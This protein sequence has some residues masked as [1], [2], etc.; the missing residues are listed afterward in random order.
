MRKFLRYVFIFLLIIFCF[1]GIIY[2][3]CINYT[4]INTRTTIVLSDIDL[5]NEVDNKIRKKKLTINDIIKLT[6]TLTSNHL[7]FTFNK[8][9][10]NSNIVSKNKKANCIGYAALFNSI[11]NY[12]LKKQQLTNTYKFTHVVGKLDFLGFDIHQLINN[13][14]FKDHDFNK[15]ENLKTGK[16]YF[17]DPSLTD[18]FYIDFVKSNK[19]SP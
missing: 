3:L 15:V 16:T 18:Y 11:G 13:P 9:S 12:I 4:I 1:K 17:I 7:K 2:R 5:Q 8:T 14:F 6:N 19:K 10:S